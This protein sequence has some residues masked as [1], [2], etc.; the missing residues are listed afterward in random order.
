MPMAG[1]RMVSVPLTMLGVRSTARLLS[2]RSLLRSSDRSTFMKSPWRW[3]EA[4]LTP[5][6]TGMVRVSLS[7]WADALSDRPIKVDIQ[8]AANFISVRFLSGFKIHTPD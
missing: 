6:P 7:V 3:S 5:T 8:M 2:T 1:R 4:L